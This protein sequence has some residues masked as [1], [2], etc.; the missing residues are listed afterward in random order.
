MEIGT[1]LNLEIIHEDNKIQKYRCKI[2]DKDENYLYIDYPVNEAT[3]RTAVL[4][5][6]TP[7]T[8]NYIGKDHVVYRFSSEVVTKVKLNIPA[9]AITIPPKDQLKRIQRRKHVRVKTAVDIAIHST[10]DS[11]A[12]FVTITN[13]ISGGGVS[14]ILP[15]DIELE[16]GMKAEIWMV[17]PMK[18]GSFEYINTKAEVVYITKNGIKRASFKF[19]DLSE[20][21]QQTVIKYSFEKQREERRKEFQ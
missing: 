14:I 20:N 21:D 2:I 6:E 11:F 1:P 19:I 9:L 17:C 15:K 16:A 4:P 10:D 12:P 7:L 8:V 18:S 3:K 13:D 5:K